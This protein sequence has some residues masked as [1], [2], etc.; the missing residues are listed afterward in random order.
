[1]KELQRCFC[2]TFTLLV[3]VWC[4]MTGCGVYSFTGASISPDI[5]TVS[6]AEFPNQTAIGSAGISQK[7]TERLKDKFVS[8]TNLDLVNQDADIEFSGFISGYDITSKAP[9]GQQTTALNRLNITVKIDFVN[10]KNLD[11]GWSQS[12]SRFADY[13]SD[14]NLSSIEDELIEEINEQLVEDI[15][16]KA[17]VNW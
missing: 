9:T 8:E 1:M 7:F 5:K 17:L 6:I 10:N 13:E 4:G 15:F 16:N 3:C 11:D 2:S 14:Q 12:F